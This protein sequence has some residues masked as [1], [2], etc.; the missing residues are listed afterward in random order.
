M[1]VALQLAWVLASAVAGVESGTREHRGVPHRTTAHPPQPALADPR[2]WQM[3]DVAEWVTQIGLHE[4]RGAFHE[5]KV[6][7]AR[8][9]TL[10]LAQLEDELLI[11]SAE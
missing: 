6:D 5:S 1:L 8:L 2:E 11:S 4:Y 7:G 10:A 9:L 3:E